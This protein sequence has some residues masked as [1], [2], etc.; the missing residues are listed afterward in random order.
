VYINTIVK[1][2]KPSHY[3]PGKALTAP[4]SWGF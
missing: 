1:E 2:V 3:R 4:G